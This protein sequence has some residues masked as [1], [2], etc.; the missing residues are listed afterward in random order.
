MRVL[1]PH[2]VLTYEHAAPPGFT[3]PGRCMH[4]N[5]IQHGQV[6]SLDWATFYPGK[7]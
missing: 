4:L 7:P 5:T 2:I 3:L 1:S 6:Q